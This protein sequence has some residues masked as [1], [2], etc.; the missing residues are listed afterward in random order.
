MAF[1]S[2]RNPWKK[3]REEGE[4]MLVQL[5]ATPYARWPQFAKDTFAYLETRAP[6][7][8]WQY[9]ERLPK[10]YLRST[11]RTHVFVYLATSGYPK[12]ETL[13]IDKTAFDGQEPPTKLSVK[14]EDVQS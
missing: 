8:A 2:D 5:A 14:V 11:K 10:E 12:L 13:Y 4:A 7:A 1:T 6:T 9:K 3:M